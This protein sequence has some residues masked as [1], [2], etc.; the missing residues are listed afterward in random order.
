MVPLVEDCR[1]R[2][3][4][5]GKIPSDRRSR[6]DNVGAPT[7]GEVLASRAVDR[8]IRPLL[9]KGVYNDEED[10]AEITVGVQSRGRPGK[11]ANGPDLYP[12]LE[13]GGTVALAINSALAA[14]LSSDQ[15]FD[16]P[17]GAIR[18]CLAVNG[19]VH[20]DSPPATLESSL[21]DL[22][23]AGTDRGVVMPDFTAR[24]AGEP[25]SWGRDDD[26]D[27]VVDTRVPEETAEEMIRLGYAAILPIIEA[28]REHVIAAVAMGEGKF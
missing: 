25:L 21:L 17:V 1:E 26:N 27:N 9:S 2:Y 20:V 7:K 28:Q 8:S 23:L 24:P 22:L 11:G 3:H 16:G 6:R 19:S 18:M 15:L 5:V 4:G 12:G 13:G 10:K 14:I